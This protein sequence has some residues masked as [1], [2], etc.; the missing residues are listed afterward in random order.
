MQITLNQQEIET[1]LK[2][3]VCSQI[4][5]NEGQEIA[6]ELKAGRSEAG[7]TATLDIRP[8]TD[9]RSAAKKPAFSAD[10]TTAAVAEKPAAVAA[11]SVFAKPKAVAAAKPVVQP[12]EVEEAQASISTGEEREPVTDVQEADEEVQEV[13]AK[14]APTRASIF[15]KVANS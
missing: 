15:S 3:Y 8:A 5:I 14:P 13:E 10:T 4:N 9:V 6:I 1:A 2:A 11:T 12:E 7:Y